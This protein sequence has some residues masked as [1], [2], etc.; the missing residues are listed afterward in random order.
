MWEILWERE[1]RG[2]Y[3]VVG[4]AT[5][6]APLQTMGFLPLVGLSEQSWGWDLVSKRLWHNGKDLGV[7]PEKIPG[8]VVPDSIHVVL[9]MDKKTLG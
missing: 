7:Y 4:V 2:S 5:P 3:A 8:F 6:R 1:E 9:D